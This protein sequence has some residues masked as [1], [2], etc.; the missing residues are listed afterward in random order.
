MGLLEKAGKMQT[1]EPKAAKKK[2]E[3]KVAE[4][5]AA[6][7]P[8]KE[9]RA[10]KER[11]PRPKRERKARVPRTMPEGYESAG[12]AAKFARRLVDTIVTY[13]ALFGTLG[14]FAMVDSDF[15]IFWIASLALMLVNI[16]V[17]PW[18]T[19]RSVGMFLTRTR[20]I[21]WKGN[22]PHWSHQVLRNL[23]TMFVMAS[24]IGIA[25]G[26]GGNVSGE[27]N[28]TTIGIGVAIGLIPVSNYIFTKIRLANGQDQ[29]MWDTMYGAWL[30]VGAKDESES[31]GRWMSRLESLGDWGEKRGWAGADTEED[32]A[33]D[34]EGDD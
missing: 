25:I 8:R 32:D 7:K 30:V 33:V 29:N 9:R 22:H 34:S 19:N 4:P 21:N 13:G 2:A 28:W 6:R 24:I 11:T 12:K 16:A 23:T 3:K 31:G 27:M 15:T 20:F 5:K 1:D 14:T 17:L 10:K 18:K 26:A